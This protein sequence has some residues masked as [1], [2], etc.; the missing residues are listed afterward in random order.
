M[1]ILENIDIDIDIDKA[2][3]QNIDI[4]K[5]SNRFKFGISNRAMAGPL[6]SNLDPVT[7]FSDLV[8]LRLGVHSAKMESVKVAFEQFHCLHWTQSS[9]GGLSCTRSIITCFCTLAASSH[10]N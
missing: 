6:S 5:I 10:S 7:C 4:D 8:D 2:I 3:L 9:R 1:V